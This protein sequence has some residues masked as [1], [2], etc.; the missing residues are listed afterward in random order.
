MTIDT[1]RTRK[2]V[3][4]DLSQKLGTEV[5]PANSADA[6]YGDT[7]IFADVDGETQAYLAEGA[8]QHQ[9]QSKADYVVN[10]GLLEEDGNLGATAG[11]YHGDI[12]DN[13]A[14]MYGADIAVMGDNIQGRDENTDVSLEPDNRKAGEG[15][16]KRTLEEG[17]FR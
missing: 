6:E 8:V 5:A 1:I 10:A 7:L 14:A 4:D 13:L 17:E 12:P 11:Q 9:A 15:F 3:A 16:I 2:T